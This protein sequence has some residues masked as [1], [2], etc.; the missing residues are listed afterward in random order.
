MEKQNQREVAIIKSL[1]QPDESKRAQ[2]DL[3]AVTRKHWMRFA[4]DRG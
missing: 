2:E 4:K 3:K 1:T